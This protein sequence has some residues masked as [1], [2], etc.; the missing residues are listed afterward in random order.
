MKNRTLAATLIALAL[1]M[2]P[3]AGAQAFT[4]GWNF[5]HATDCAGGPAYGLDF[6]LVY[7][8]EGGTLVT[9]DPVTVSLIAPFCA[10][11]Q[12]FYVNINGTTWVGTSVPSSFR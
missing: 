1:L 11:G 10:S 2:S 3:I 12:G 4:N 6:V 7:P 5:I 8:N 9:T